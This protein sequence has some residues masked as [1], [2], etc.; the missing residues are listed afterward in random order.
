MKKYAYIPV[1]VCSKKIEIE[2]NDDNTIESL[3]VTGGCNGNLKGIASL[4]KG[5]KVDEVISNL[6]G[7]KCGFKDTS[8]PDQIAKALKSIE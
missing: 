2:V 5:R 6:E 4:C 3:V 8:C 1:G 7:I